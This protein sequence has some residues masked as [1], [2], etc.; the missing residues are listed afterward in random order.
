MVL[1]ALN[2]MLYSGCKHSPVIDMTIPLDDTTSVDSVGIPCNPDS[3]YFSL[4]ILPILVS[5]CAMDNCH[6]NNNPEE[7]INLTTYS[8]V[9]T[10]ADIKPGQLTGDLWEAIN[11]TDP[12]KRMPAPPRTPLTTEQINLIRKW[13][14]QGALDKS[15]DADAGG[16]NTLDRSFSQHILPILKNTCTGCHSGSSPS[17][18]INLS[19][20]EGVSAVASNGRLTGAIKKLTSYAAM[21]PAGN[22]LSPCN[23]DKI[24]AWI[25]QGIKNN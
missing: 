12:D 10:T 25:A 19:T 22:A 5:N 15:C 6:S 16:C 9:M 4:Q 17:G 23:V 14:Q 11:E 7:G 1:I 2:P 8:K 24:E 3:V 18:N 21:P 13:I 20:F